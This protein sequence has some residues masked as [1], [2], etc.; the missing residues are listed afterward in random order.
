VIIQ[1]YGQ[2]KGKKDIKIQF[3]QRIIRIYAINPGFN[4]FRQT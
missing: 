1:V 3:W 4:L 2:Y